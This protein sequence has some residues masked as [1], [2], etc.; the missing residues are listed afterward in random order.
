MDS[1]TGTGL[2]S[3]ATI[4]YLIIG[5][6]LAGS[7]LAWQLDQHQ[8]RVLI[9]DCAAEHSASSIAAGIVNPVAGQRLVKYPYAEICLSKARE[10]YSAI[11]AFFKQPFY[12]ERPMIRLFKTEKD[13]QIWAERL[14]DQAYTPYLSECFDSQHGV[15]VPAN[16]LGGFHQNHSGYLDTHR[17][18][19]VLRE[20]FKSKQCLI[21][22]KFS[23]SQL[24]LDR[25][26]PV[27][28]DL[29]AGEIINCEGFHAGAN[30]YFSW[31]PFQL[32]KGEILT[33]QSDKS[34][35]DSIINKGK[36]VL[37]I[38]KNILRSG[39]TFQWEPLDTFP[40]K[41][42]R[43]L[44]GSSAYEMT[45]HGTKIQ[46]LSQEAGI[47]AGTLDKYPFVGTHPA[48]PQLRIFNGFGSRGVLTIPYYAE[49]FVQTLLRKVPLPQE[50]DIIRYRCGW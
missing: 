2:K 13:R 9:V 34:L 7:I 24:S 31:L 22:A 30:D 46:L 37:P 47:R 49:C 32:S 16:R 5:Q 1:Y 18:L 4:D 36:W 42:A 38:N 6:G 17:F 44:L 14:T 8:Q 20:Y 28:K 21:E 50:V 43:D 3:R 29:N 23:W 40:S 19:A 35:L 41:S 11:E 25:E 26:N 27:W 15:Q 10:F 45:R 48:F 39:A 12:F 33:M